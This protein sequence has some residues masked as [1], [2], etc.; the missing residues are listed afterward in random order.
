MLSASQT[1][2]R[3]QSPPEGRLKPWRV[4]TAHAEG[5]VPT[6]PRLA[7]PGG[8]EPAGLPL[9]VR[10]GELPALRG[11]R[12]TSDLR[13]RLSPCP[14][15]GSGGVCE[16]KLPGRGVAWDSWGHSSLLYCFTDST[17]VT[18]F[19]GRVLCC[20][21]CSE[22]SACGGRGCV[23]SREGQ[24]TTRPSHVPMRAAW[25]LQVLPLP[26]PPPLL[27]DEGNFPGRG[28]RL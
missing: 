23:S 1:R 6:W 13:A 18:V 7:A 11:L 5:V 25:H 17:R 10:R 9:S 19:A 3:K 14:P 16:W 20:R 15:V 24:V 4:V 21:H 8:Q 27:C 2:L 26:K 22:Q 12:L 28:T